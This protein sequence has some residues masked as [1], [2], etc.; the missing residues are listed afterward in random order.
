MVKVD[1]E[2]FCNSLLSI[3]NNIY[4]QEKVPGCQDSHILKFLRIGEG[5]CMGNF[6]LSFVSK[7]AGI[8]AFLRKYAGF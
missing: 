7:F 8:M 2:R 6:A 3:E 5:K 1:I 4:F